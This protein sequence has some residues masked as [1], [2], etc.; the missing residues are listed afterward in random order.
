[1]PR[2]RRVPELHR[3]RRR[4]RYQWCAR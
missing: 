1:M 3:V 4:L 2:R